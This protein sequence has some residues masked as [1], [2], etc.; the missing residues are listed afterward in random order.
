MAIDLTQTAFDLVRQIFQVVGI[1]GLLALMAVE[2]FGIPPLPS[3]IIL[4][5]AGIAIASPLT[6]APFLGIPFTWA[7]VL[8][9]SLAGSLIGASFAYL[10]GLAYGIPVLR[11]VGGRFGLSEADIDRAQRFFERRGEITVALCRMVPLIRAYVSYP[12]GAAEMRFPRFAVFTLAGTL[13]F[14]VA[15]VY[16]GVVLGENLGTFESYFHLL[17]VVVVVAIALVA[18]WVIVKMHRRSRA[19]AARPEPGT[20]PTGPA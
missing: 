10:L 5:L 16:V 18:L 8:T 2:S 15:L 4:P 6:G 12:A 14:T 1:P 9:A 17:D 7:T 3:E 11:A 13:P 20:P 19:R